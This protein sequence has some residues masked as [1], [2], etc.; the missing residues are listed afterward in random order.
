MNKIH[1]LQQLQIEKS[2]L[3]NRSKE[4]ELKIK[5]GWYHV[6]HDFDPI[7]MAKETYNIYI[8]KKIEKKIESEKMMDKTLSYGIALLAEKVINIFNKRIGKFFNK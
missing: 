6:K 4:L 1:S 8:N 2:R 3:E 5:A 7:V